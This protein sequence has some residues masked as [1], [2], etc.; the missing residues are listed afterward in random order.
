MIGRCT[1]TPLPGLT[2]I[3]TINATV[4][5][6]INATAAA[7]QL[8]QLTSFD[9][10]LR[11][12]SNSLSSS[13]PTEL[14]QIDLSVVFSVS[15][16]TLTGPVRHEYNYQLT[17]ASTNAKNH[18]RRRR[19]CRRRRRRRRMCNRQP[20]NIANQYRRQVPTQL[21]LGLAKMTRAFSIYSNSIS[22][23]IPTQVNISKGLSMSS[24]QHVVFHI[25]PTSIATTR[26]THT[27]H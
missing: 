16:N 23:T 4:I 5:T 18:R 20:I 17:N 26:P 2:T 13:I 9:G 11:L 19:R 22:S 10:Y 12:Y 1:A 24:Q 14:G 8:G 15:Q 6:T 3:A 7:L 21:G 27:P 25:H